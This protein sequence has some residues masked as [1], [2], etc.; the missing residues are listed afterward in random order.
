MCTAT[1]LL[2]ILST[3]HIIVDS[4]RVWVGF[5]RAENAEIYFSDVSKETWKNAIYEFETLIADGVL[6]Y[7]CYIV[8]RSVWVIVPPIVGYCSVIVAGTHTVWSIAQLVGNPNDIFINETSQWVI[9]F[10]ALA[11]ATNFV[12]TGLLA[13]KLWTSASRVAP[14]GGSSLRPVLIVIMECGALY[15]VSLLV[16]ITTY[17]AH[18][19]AAYVVIDIIGQI[20]PITFY[21]VIIRATM[22][23]IK[24]NQPS[25]IQLS[26]P[27]YAVPSST[28]A[29][30]DS[31]RTKPMEV[32]IARFVDRDRTSGTHFGGKD[33]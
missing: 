29:T 11:L 15:S 1:C 7:R 21:M 8:W 18:T 25:T 28:I 26:E 32:H 24:P 30:T 27:V 22:I 10:Y 31:E 5:I 20:I 12:A 14:H 6:I 9:S 16:M 17:R 33:F 23:K 13:Y 2:L 19:N 4:R 3:M